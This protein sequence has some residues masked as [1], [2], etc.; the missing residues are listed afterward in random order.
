MHARLVDMVA[1][2]AVNFQTMDLYDLR[3]LPDHLAGAG[4]QDELQVLLLNFEYLQAKLQYTHINDLLDDF[5]YVASHRR[6]TPARLV[7]EALRLSAHTLAIDAT[8]LAGQLI[9]R[10][11][12]MPQPE[13]HALVAQAEAWTGTSWIR[14]LHSVLTAPGGAMLRTLTGHT[15]DVTKVSFSRNGEHLL[16]TSRDKSLKVWDLTS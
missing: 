7:Q 15:D 6:Q 8:Q 4:R 3:Y 9:G 16:S 2:T 12:G 13:L 5:D 10:L 14:P 11:K 1:I